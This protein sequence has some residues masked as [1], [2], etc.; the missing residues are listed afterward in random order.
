MGNKQYLIDVIDLAALRSPYIAFLAVWDDFWM[1]NIIPDHVYRNCLH[2]LADIANGDK[3]FSL[4]GLIM[5]ELV[6]P[7]V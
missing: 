3:N 7:M 5:R 2:E 1:V 6:V 4:C